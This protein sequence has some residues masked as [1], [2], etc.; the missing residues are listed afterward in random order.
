MP[1]RFTRLTRPA[2][3]K[4]QAG[5]R[6]TEYG[7]TAERL[8][9]GDV[10]YSVNVMVDGERIHRVIGRA[11]DGTTRTQAEDFIAK[12][13]ADA[14]ERR[15]NL[16]KGRKVAL[17]FAKAAALYMNHLRDTGGKGISEKERH[18]RLHLVP[19]L[20]NMPLDR[21]SKFTLEKYRRSRK[22]L[23][24]KPGAINRTLAT[25]RHM[26]N[27]LF[28]LGKIS[29]PMPMIKLDPED[30][31]RDYVLDAE[32]KAALLER[33]LND[34]NPHIWLF[35]MI[36]LHTSLRHAEILSTRFQNFDDRRRRL[37]VRVKGGRWRDQPL[38]RKITEILQRERDMA[39]DPDGWIFPS[40]RGRKEH[41][42]SM[43]SAFHRVV[44]AVGLDPKKV[45]PHTMR[46]TA[47]TEMAE[48]GAEARTIQ[49]FSGHRS[50]EMVWRYTHARDERVDQALD[51]FE[52]EGAK[53]ERLPDRKRPRS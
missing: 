11:S 24:L 43:K 2:I 32:E 47:I 5:K 51:R 31:R 19:D 8:K 7:I 35:I 45:T 4:L 27:E 37:R 39:E 15:L 25:Y 14:K 29:A 20:G 1:L 40:S 22:A 48:T 9:D 21:I 28:E 44:I 42:L 26:T 41:V 6:I 18:L 10:R 49:A 33:A 53:V 12:T 38:T 46:H 30:D 23:G 34:S 16:P 17:S 36:G 50:K 52:E 3:R 13:R